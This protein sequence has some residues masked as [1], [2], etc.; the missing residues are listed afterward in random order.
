MSAHPAIA[1]AA[2]QRFFPRSDDSRREFYSEISNAVDSGTEPDFIIQ[3]WHPNAVRFEIITT[4]TTP[5]Y[6]RDLYALSASI[7]PAEEMLRTALFSES[8]NYVGIS[9][10]KVLARENTPKRLDIIRDLERT[11]EL[12]SYLLIIYNLEKN[13]KHR[14]AS[15]I[16][17]QFIETR[18]SSS[19]L[20]AVNALLEAVDLSKM[21]VYSIAGLIRFTSRAKNHLPYWANLFAQAKKI[22]TEKGYKTEEV[23]IGIKG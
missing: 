3:K 4:K 2:I 16:V 1:S 19:N 6:T 14:S 12:S 9:E 8:C 17:F 20:A 21:S 10:Y 13:G 15:K 23:L 7:E 5:T 22:L 11:P 18:F